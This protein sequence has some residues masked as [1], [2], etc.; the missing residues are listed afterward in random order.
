[1]RISLKYGVSAV[2]LLAAASLTQAQTNEHQGGERGGAA[3]PHT[4][5]ERSGKEGGAVQH[6]GSAAGEH[7]RNGTAQRGERS[8]K[9]NAQRE[10]TPGAQRSNGKPAQSEKQGRAEE[11]ARGKGTQ[12]ERQ[13][14]NERQAKTNPAPGSQ[15]NERNGQNAERQ[16]GRNAQ[17][18][19]GQRESNV[20]GA[21]RNEELG[22]ESRRSGANRASIHISPAQKTELHDVIVHDT[23]IHRYRHGE[24]KFAVN[25]G[26]RIPASVEFYD[27]PARFVEI[28]PEFRGYKIVV[29]DGEILVIDPATREIVDV[30]SRKSVDFW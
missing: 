21:A 28:E 24:I 2:A 6:Q 11:H 9:S 7:E 4:Q 27:P 10:E 23:S 29:L 19:R 15:G 18:E 30:I 17:S 16:G 12:N 25:I 3:A 1:M 26:T 5:T 13:S 14:Q 22:R 8:A 20:G